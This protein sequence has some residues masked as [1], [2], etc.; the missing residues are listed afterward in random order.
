MKFE[1]GT[2]I[3]MKIPE[4]HYAETV[5]FYRDVLLL[6]VE[7]KEI[8]HPTVLQTCKVKFGP[9]TLWLDCV[10][11]ITDTALWLEIKTPDIDKATD[12]LNTNETATHDELEKIPADMHWIKDPAGTVLLLNGRK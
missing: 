8:N 9:C 5:H 1:A 10:K 4:H 6:E 2:N 11:D 12:Y 7:E 3:A